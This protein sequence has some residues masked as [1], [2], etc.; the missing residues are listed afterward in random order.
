M[1]NA[2]KSLDENAEIYLAG[3]YAKG[4]WLEDSDID[5]IIISKIFQGKDIGKRYSTIKKLASSG[6]SL[7]VLA[8]SPSD[9]KRYSKRSAILRDMLETAIKLTP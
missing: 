1:L 8:Y 6:F 9:F 7:E 4:D 5:L 2:V 3:S